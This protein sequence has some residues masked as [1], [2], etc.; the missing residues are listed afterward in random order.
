MSERHE[1][2]RLDDLDR[3][4]V[5][6]R[7]LEWRPVRRRL[8]IRAFGINAYTSARPGGEVVEE[9]TEEQLGHEEVYVV[10]RGHATFVLGG[11]SVDAPAGT[12]VYLR[13]PE[14]RRSATAVD[15]DTLVLAVGGKPGEAFVPSAWESYFSAAPLA[16][17]GKLDEAIGLML[18]DAEA[19]PDVPALLYNLACYEALGGRDADALAHLARAI[20]LSP[21]FRDFAEKDADFERLRGDPRFTEALARPSA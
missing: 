21:R 8:G 11:E 18:R 2:V 19:R 3:V 16:K 10:V 12:L 7:G 14:V 9:H 13:D 15:A 17:E 6:D 20:E 1:V 4:E 5:G